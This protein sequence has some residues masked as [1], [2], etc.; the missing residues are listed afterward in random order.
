MTDIETS[1][2]NFKC[3]ML[4]CVSSVQDKKIKY[5]LNF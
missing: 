3:L 4:V 2:N 5:T 1:V